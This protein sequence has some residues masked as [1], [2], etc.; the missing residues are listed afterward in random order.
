MLKPKNLENI[1][2]ATSK[3]KISVLFNTN[4][5]EILDKAVILKANESEEIISL[6]ND[7]VYIFAGGILPTKFLESIGIKITKKFGEA[8]LQ[9]Q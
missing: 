1:N 3:K 5:V 2:N 7:L 8:I 6:E 4:V 9:H